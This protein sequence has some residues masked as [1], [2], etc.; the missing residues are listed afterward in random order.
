MDN[1]NKIKCLFLGHNWELTD[2]VKG[3][4]WKWNI[5]ICLRCRKI[6]INE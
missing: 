5:S 1:K 6:K 4:Y 2:F 3:K